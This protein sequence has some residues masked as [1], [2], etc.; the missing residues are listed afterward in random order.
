MV[1]RKLW[2]GWAWLVVV[3]CFAG[4]AAVPNLEHLYPAGGLPGTTNALAISGK[5]EPWPPRFWVEGE[6]VVIQ[7]TTNVGKA[8]VAIATNA[9]PGPRWVRAYNDEGASDPR[10]FVVGVGNQISDVEPN[11]SFASPQMISALPVTIQGRLDKNGDVDSFGVAVREGEWLEAR[12]DAYSLMSKLD[13]VLRL[14]STNGQPL[15]WNHDF[16]TFDPRVSWRAPSAQTVV[17]QVFGF[18]YPADSSIQLTGGEGAVYQLHLA[19]SSEIPEAFAGVRP[20]ETSEVFG[21]PL[22][23]R[24]ALASSASEGRYRFRATKDETIECRVDAANLGAGW[25]ARLRIEDS[26]GKELAQNDDGEGTS[27]P[28]LD[29]KAPADGEYVAVVGSRLR[30]G[31]ADLRYG[32]TVDRGVPSIRATSPVSSW[33]VSAGG[34]NEVKVA[35][36]RR[37]GYTNAV[38]VGFQALPR[39]VTSAMESVDAGKNE[40][41]LKVVARPDAGAF[42]GPVE[43]QVI[44]VGGGR[45]N[46]VAF[47][48]VSRGENNGVPQGYSK[49]L[50]ESTEALWLTV[51]SAAAAAPKP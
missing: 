1:H 38:E 24:G 30:S 29:W 10:L 27:D 3:S 31:S 36:V 45:T 6:G 35:I 21:L 2:V 7:A 19:A 46:R 17:V 50:R 12:V 37:H 51:R 22:K 25:D 48:L 20:V 28:R 33:V 40:V 18:K 4:R 11:G 44:P 39:G 43:I 13:A 32:L 26:A 5:S 41:T 42:S 23:V 8:E 34:T 14:V 15:A 16:D 49:L 9:V 47:D